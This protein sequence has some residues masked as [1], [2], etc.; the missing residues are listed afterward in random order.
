MQST[1]FDSSQCHSSSYQNLFKQSCK[2]AKDPSK[3]LNGL[4][5]YC[6]N[7]VQIDKDNTTVS[8]LLKCYSNIKCTGADDCKK[9]MEQCE[10]IK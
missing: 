1:K 2:L 10:K 8:N 9:Q 5:E 6:A 7:N 4:T 3:C